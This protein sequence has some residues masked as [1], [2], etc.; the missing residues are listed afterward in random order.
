M[1]VPLRGIDGLSGSLLFDIPWMNLK[2]CHEIFNSITDTLQ[3]FIRTAADFGL[4][5]SK[6]GE[7]EQKK[8]QN[9]IH[10]TYFF[11]VYV[12][13]GSIKYTLSF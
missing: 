5:G 12:L 11:S 3:V 9:P 13:D 10:D 7:T 8:K 2:V 6:M 1:L 4:T